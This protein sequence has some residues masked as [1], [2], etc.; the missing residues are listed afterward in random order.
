MTF[1]LLPDPLPHPPGRVALGGAA[2]GERHGNV[3]QTKRKASLLSP[4]GLLQ[5]DVR[6]APVAGEPPVER[7]KYQFLVTT[8]AVAPTLAVNGRPAREVNLSVQLG[9]ARESTN[10]FVTLAGQPGHEDLD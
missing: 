7:S 9:R 1:S 3:G 2:A 10:P 4:M 8:S 6:R 5:L